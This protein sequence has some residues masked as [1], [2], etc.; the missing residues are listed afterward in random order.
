MF[1]GGGGSLAGDEYLMFENCYNEPVMIDL[2]NVNSSLDILAQS[3]KPSDQ[4]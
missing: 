2:N 4:Q 1:W 3:Q